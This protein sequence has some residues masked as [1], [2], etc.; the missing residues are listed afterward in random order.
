MSDIDTAICKM[1]PRLA[2]LSVATQFR[3]QADR[4]YITARHTYALGFADQF[5]WSAQQALEKYLKATAIF[6]IPLSS[7]DT[8]SPKIKFGKG[9]MGH[10]LVVIVNTL[11][12]ASRFDI[13][14]SEETKNFLKH[15]THHG[16]NRYSQLFVNRFGNELKLLDEHV[17]KVRGQ[18]FWW[19]F[20]PPRGDSE[21][22]V[23]AHRWNEL[24]SEKVSGQKPGRVQH[25]YGL[26]EAI[27]AP[28][29]PK[30][31]QEA[32]RSLIRWNRWFFYSRRSGGPA[33]MWTDRAWPVW[34]SSW[35]SRP[36]V[37]QV[38]VE[39]GLA[40]RDSLRAS[41]SL[42]SGDAIDWTQIRFF[43]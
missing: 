17:W 11:C 22:G 26:L 28:N 43:R 18:C 34:G 42:S 24:R 15:V 20:D 35:I 23:D 36:E 27:M 38:L 16:M 30:T 7:E 6:L 4:D 1:G 12:D 8:N 37:V 21:H 29:A 9:G 31:D 5:M 14:Y 10:D 3:D 41:K 32:R 13:S 33:P 25:E 39:M 2:L 40:P 19:Q